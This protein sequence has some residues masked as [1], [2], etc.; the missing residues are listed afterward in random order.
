MK[1][2]ARFLLAALVMGATVSLVACDKETKDDPTPEVEII[3][4]DWQSETH[5]ASNSYALH[6]NNVPVNAGEVVDYEVSESD[7][8]LDVAMPTLVI[9]NLT[10][11]NLMTSQKVELVEGPVTMQEVEICGGGNCPWD[12]K[13]YEI[14]PGLNPDKSI[15]VKVHPSKCPDNTTAVYRI[16][17]GQ[18]SEL[19]NPQVIFVRIKL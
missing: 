18:T 5:E 11:E 16:T 12:G 3:T 14:V 7:R 9:E 6:F 10:K 13:D 19:A 2:T 1:K 4:T 15:Y 17:V 8:S